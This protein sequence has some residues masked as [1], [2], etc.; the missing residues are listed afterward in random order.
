M[1]ELEE[2]SNFW[3]TIKPGT[4]FVVRGTLYHM[5]APSS[6]HHTED[7]LFNCATGTIHHYSELFLMADGLNRVRECIRK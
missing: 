2:W 3:K 4:K 7:S 5:M 6:S 1:D